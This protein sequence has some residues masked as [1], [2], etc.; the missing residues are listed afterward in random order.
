VGPSWPAGGPARKGRERHMRARS[1]TAV[2]ATL[3]LAACDKEPTKLDR[4]AEAAAAPPTPTAS[5]PRPPPIPIAP[6]ITVDDGACGVNGEEVLF[7]AADA[8][9]RIAALLSGKPLVEGKVVA[10]DAAREAK[11]PRVAAVVSALRKAK[12]AGASIH[13]AM[14]DKNMGELVLHFTHAA[15]SE[16]TPVAMIARDGAIAVWGAAGGTA[17]KFTR[18]FA[19]PD[20]TLGSDGL[21]K[22][23]AA[24]GS[25]VWALGADDNIPWGLT[26]DLAMRARGEADAGGGIKATETVLLAEPPVAGRKV[27]VP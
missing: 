6:A 14:R 27:D 20:L 26:F 2:A 3:A 4:I 17:Q 1:W 9:D 7:A 23:S 8:K 24:C 13:T 12:A 25:T 16:C 19:G 5:A 10:F 15:A 18:G 22:L 11:T 21:R